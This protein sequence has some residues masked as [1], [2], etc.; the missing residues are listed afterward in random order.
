MKQQEIEQEGDSYTPKQPEYQP[1]SNFE[2][3]QEVNNPIEKDL[4]Q[5]QLQKEIE[6]LESKDPL[7]IGDV[8]DTIE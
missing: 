4:E 3:E 1:S 8:V 2:V 7:M 5:E 6:E